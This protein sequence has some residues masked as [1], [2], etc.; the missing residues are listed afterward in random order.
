MKCVH[1]KVSLFAPL[2][3]YIYKSDF[4]FKKIKAFPLFFKNII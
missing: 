2:S 1:L 4:F 3:I